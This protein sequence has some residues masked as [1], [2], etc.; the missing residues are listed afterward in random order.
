ATSAS[1]R[2][3]FRERSARQYS[4][5]TAATLPGTRDS[6]RAVAAETAH[7]SD[8]SPALGLDVR[9]DAPLPETLA[10]GAGTALFVCGTC[11]APG[12]R[13]STLSL[14]VDGEEQSLLAH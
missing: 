12:G 11:F 14:L 8:A 2:P 6:L 1:R 9:L 7:R 10:V 3:G 13:V 4:S 5:D